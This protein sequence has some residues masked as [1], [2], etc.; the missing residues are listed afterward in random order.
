VFI[1]LSLIVLALDSTRSTSIVYLRNRHDKEPRISAA[2]VLMGPL[3]PL[4]PLECSEYAEDQNK[5]KILSNGQDSET[6]ISKR[7]HYTKIS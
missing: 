5:V 4:Y 6:A 3:A 7:R 2:T 1:A